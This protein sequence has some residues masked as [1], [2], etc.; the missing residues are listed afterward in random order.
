MRRR[1]CS[2]LG[3][4]FLRGGF[5]MKLRKFD[6][7]I[8]RCLALDMFTRPCILVNFSKGNNLSHK[9]QRSLFPAWLL[10]CSCGRGHG[11][12]LGEESQQNT[13]T[14][15]VYCLHSHDCCWKAPPTWLLSSGVWLPFWD[16]YAQ[17]DKGHTSLGCK[18]QD[19]HEK[20]YLSKLFNLAFTVYTPKLFELGFKYLTWLCLSILNCYRMILALP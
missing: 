18:S 6:S 9:V 14:H 20:N 19:P 4:C 17:E 13:D 2:G 5:N 12:V 3:I 7:V 8:F 16:T 11:K 10:S 1:W 15:T